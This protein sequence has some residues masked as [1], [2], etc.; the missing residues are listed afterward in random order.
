[1]QQIRTASGCYKAHVAGSLQATT[2]LSPWSIYLF[3]YL[4]A[5]LPVGGVPNGRGLIEPFQEFLQWERFY[6]PHIS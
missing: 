3:I 2:R 1:M 4:F 6:L 5:L